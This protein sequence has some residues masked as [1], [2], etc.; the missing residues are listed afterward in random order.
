[1]NKI[2]LTLIAI[3][4][5]SFGFCSLYFEIPKEFIELDPLEIGHPADRLL[6]IQGA[7]HPNASISIHFEKTNETL[8][9]YLKKSKIYTETSFPVSFDS[10]GVVPH[11]SFDL[12]LFKVN[13]LS[14]NFQMEL[15]H[16]YIQSN[17]VLYLI[18]YN[19]KREDFPLYLNAFQKLL[20]SISL[21]P[22]PFSRLNLSEDKKKSLFNT[23]HEL[24]HRENISRNQ[25]L[26]HP[27]MLDLIRSELTFYEK[28]SL[29]SALMEL[30]MA[31]YE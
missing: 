21:E 30:R 11:P 29:F 5:K 25:F 20:S 2:I 7:H 13:P 4:L 17:G 19:A 9:D 24:I 28:S 14:I 22:T 18:S 31:L 15:L 10:I 16:A 8:H 26:F 27:K 3:L 1:M 23:F 12:H 6:M